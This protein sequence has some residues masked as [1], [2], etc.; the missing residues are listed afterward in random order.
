M[1]YLGPFCFPHLLLQ[2]VCGL[3][4]YQVKCSCRFDRNIVCREW[5]D[6]QVTILL[7]NR[8]FP[9][10]QAAKDYL[11]LDTPCLCVTVTG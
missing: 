1:E 4:I 11:E 2:F 5:N 8:K 3:I 6:I 9:P 10:K 7:M